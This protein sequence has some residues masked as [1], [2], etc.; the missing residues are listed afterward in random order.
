M[1]DLEPR[2]A[3]ISQFTAQLALQPEVFRN[4]NMSPLDL[5]GKV[6]G[7]LDDYITDEFIPR[8]SEHAAQDLLQGDDLSQVADYGNLPMPCA[9]L[10]KAAY[11]VEK[12]V[13]DQLAAKRKQHLSLQQNYSDLRKRLKRAQNAEMKLPRKLAKRS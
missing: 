13:G 11:F 10:V 9:R 4:Q 5:A 2:V 8:W 3:L 1:A 12:E 6:E 7:P